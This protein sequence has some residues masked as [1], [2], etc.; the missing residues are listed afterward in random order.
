MNRSIPPFSHTLL[1]HPQHP[2][3]FCAHL[4]LRYL[5]LGQTTDHG[6]ASSLLPDEP[7]LPLVEASSPA[8]SKA[9]PLCSSGRVTARLS[10]WTLLRGKGGE[11]GQQQNPTTPVSPPGDGF[12]KGYK[13]TLEIRAQKEHT[14]PSRRKKI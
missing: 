14:K 7:A 8:I 9:D 6:K 11:F 3:V 2:H 5:K 10:P 12:S 13:D 4:R 1:P